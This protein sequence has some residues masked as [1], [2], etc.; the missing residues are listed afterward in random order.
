[1]NL[2]YRI[3][4]ADDEDAIRQTVLS[5][6]VRAGFHVQA[7]TGGV[8]ACQWLTNEPFD[9]VV[10]DIWMPDLDGLHVLQTA[11]AL[12]DPPEVVLMTGNSTVTTAVAALRAGAFN[13]L[14]KPCDSEELVATVLAAAQRREVARRRDALLLRIAGDVAAVLGTATPQPQP[15]AAAPPEP[16]PLVRLGKLELTPARRAA[17]FAGQPLHLTPTEYSLIEHLIT[18][19]RRVCRW[20]DLARATHR[21]DLEPDEAHELLRPHI[22]HL[23]RKLAPDYLV[24]VRGVGLMLDLPAADATN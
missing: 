20:E 14:L 6:L 8:E 12:P 24:T 1:M 9:V 18:R 10:S 22:R 2:G 21:L 15:A 23:R 17:S 19:A 13:Y 3:L 16:P 7:V 11:R 4:L 5:H